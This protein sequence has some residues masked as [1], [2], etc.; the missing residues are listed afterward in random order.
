MRLLDQ[1][2]RDGRRLAPV[3]LSVRGDSRRALLSEARWRVRLGARPLLTLGLVCRTRAGH[4]AVP[5][6]CRFSFANGSFR[7]E[8][9]LDATDTQAW[10]EVSLVPPDGGRD[11]TLELSLRVDA[12]GGAGEVEAAFGEPMLH[13]QADYGRSKGVLLI[14]IDTLRR[15]HV[16]IYGYR[17]PTSPRLDALAKEGLLCDDAVSTSSWTL[18]AHVSLLT[19]LDAGQHGALDR[20]HGFN[21]RFPTLPGLLRAAGFATHAVTS[22]LY[23]SSAYGVHEGFDNLL[24][25]Q[26]QN[27]EAVTGRALALLDEAGDRPFF[28]FLHFYDP[29]W[30]YGPPKDILAL[31]ERPGSY[32]G[33]VTGSYWDFSAR[34]ALTPAD[35]DHLRALYD[36]EIRYTDG[37]IGRI[38]DHLD[39]RGLRESTLVVVTS[40]HGEEFLEHGGLEHQRTLYEEQ[41]RIP[42]IVRAPRLRTG[43]EPQQAS[44]LDVAPTVLAWAGLP[45]PRHMLGKSLL[46]ALP[47]REAYGETHHADDLTRKAFLRDGQGG[48]KLVF[49]FDKQRPALLRREEWYDLGWDPGE[50]R[51]QRPRGARAETLRRL[52]LERWERAR[53]EPPS[54]LVALTPEQ[55]ERLKSLGYVGP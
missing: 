43:R 14:S 33:N 39:E 4:P 20:D 13:D 18:P 12:S 50:Q 48:S 8:R 55:L 32:L 17:P 36:A 2:D 29:H 6:A 21:G 27:A 7:G 24:Y 44:L 26:D 25:R 54:G 47:P 41:L 19:S 35:L 1:P 52:L 5:G 15:D 42:L 28:L 38:L 22:H 30:H 10:T 49:S 16:G 3:T 45:V 11:T 9:R 37:Q 40:D 46:S 51:S 31:F 34:P 53:R 23:V